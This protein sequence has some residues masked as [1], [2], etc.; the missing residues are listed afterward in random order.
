VFVEVVSNSVTHISIKV[1]A[2]K[3]LAKER[4]KGENLEKFST[5]RKEK[6]IAAS[7]CIASPRA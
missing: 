7:A 4:I 5:T 3:E 2:G 1:T 6:T